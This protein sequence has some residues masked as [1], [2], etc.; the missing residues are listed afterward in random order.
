MNDVTVS[1]S[2]CLKASN[3]LHETSM[4]VLNA[5]RRRNFW[6]KSSHVRRCDT[7]KEANQ[8]WVIPL[9]D[10]GNNEGNLEV[11][12]LISNYEQI[13][14]RLLQRP[15]DAPT[16][17]KGILMGGSKVQPIKVAL[18]RKMVDFKGFLVEAIISSG[19]MQPS[20]CLRRDE[21]FPCEVV[22]TSTHALSRHLK[23]TSYGESS[24][25]SQ[26]SVVN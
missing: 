17:R 14:K 18:K 13:Y 24:R 7:S 19:G 3:S 8:R 2:L 1:S 26:H 4:T 22:I 15:T 9:K 11:F 25:N 5:N 12:K 6:A 10:M 21:T 23:G 16:C 20:A